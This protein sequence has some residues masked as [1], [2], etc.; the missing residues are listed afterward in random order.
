MSDLKE[1]TAVT[2]AALDL[3]P[4]RSGPCGYRVLPVRRL[5]ELRPGDELAELLAGAVELQD[6]DVVVVT[7]PATG[8]TS[9]DLPRSSPA[10]ALRTPTTISLPSAI[11]TTPR[12]RRR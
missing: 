5:P 12:K 6:G 2:P 8:G 1:M 7:S 9:P 11:A 3:A 4:E 10:K